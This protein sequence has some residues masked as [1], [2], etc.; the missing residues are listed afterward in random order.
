MALTTNG[1]RIANTTVECGVV[2]NGY[3]VRI[4]NSRASFAAVKLVA[5]RSHHSQEAKA[6]IPCNEYAVSLA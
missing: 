2:C 4:F 5:Y 1:L 3:S 6:R